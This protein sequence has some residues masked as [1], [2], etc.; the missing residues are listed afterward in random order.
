MQEYKTGRKAQSGNI[1][2]P[3]AR[4]SFPY[5]FRP[6]MPSE[7]ND[8]KKPKYSAALLF[9]ADADLT[10]LKEAAKKALEDKWGTDSTKWPDNLRSPFRDQSEKTV[11]GYTPGCKFIT[12]SSE[13]KPG[14][15]GADGNH[16]TDETLFYPGAW[17]WATVHAFAYD[18]KG[19]KGVAFGLDNIQK[20]RDDAPLAGKPRA[21]SEFAAVAE[22]AGA[23]ASNGAGSIFD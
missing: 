14:L 15:V 17:A 1:V 18:K 20:I 5:I 21:E 23:N 16:I 8:L 4:V 11:E 19:N 22:A 6:Q 3:I 2:T 12:I 9:P 10:L 13:H 7:D